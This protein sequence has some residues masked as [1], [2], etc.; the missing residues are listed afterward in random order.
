MGVSMTEPLDMLTERLERLE[1]ENG[2]WRRAATLALLVTGALALLGQASPRSRVV[3]AEKFV[4]KDSDGKVR[5]VLGREWANGRAPTLS[6]VRLT[7][8]YGLHLYGP[9]G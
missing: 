5:A 8:V 3:E 9:D 6:E 1:R 2:W 7:G 4:L